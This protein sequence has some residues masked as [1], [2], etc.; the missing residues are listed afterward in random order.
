MPIF[1]HNE[2][3][4]VLWNVVGACVLQWSIVHINRQ[5]QQIVYSISYEINIQTEKHKNNNQRK[6]N[7]YN[8]VLPLF[9]N[10]YSS[11]VP[12]SNQYPEN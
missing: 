10:A 4:S 7:D 2:L 3:N 1:F 6:T 11:C 8:F 9:T 5:T 12:T